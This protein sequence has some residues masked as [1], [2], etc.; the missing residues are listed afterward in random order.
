MDIHYNAFISYRHHP[1]DIKVA[2]QI[3]RGLEHYRI[4]KPLNQKIHTKLRLFRDKEELP[5]T[6]NLTDTITQALNNSEYLIVICSPHTR[7]SIWVQREIETFLQTHDRTRILTVIAE[8][9]PYNVIPEILCAEEQ[10]DP[11]TGQTVSVPVEPLSCDWRA[12]KRKAYREELPRLA[13]ALLEC[14][15]DELRQRERQYQ[16]RRMAAIFSAALAAALTLSAYVIHNSIKIQQANNQLT[17]ANISILNNLQQAQ[18]NQSQFLASA[19]LQQAD[20]GDRMQAMALALEALPHEDNPRPYVVR[21]EKALADA[22]GAYLSQE[23]VAAVGVITCDAYVDLF[24][25]TDQRDWLFV[26]DQRELL[27][28]WELETFQQVAATPLESNAIELLVTP[29]DTAIVHT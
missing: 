8:G 25:A 19:A 9:E 13:A 10:L 1:S 29:D 20:A 7:E 15:Y 3:H 28:V 21:A 12:S 16:T 27:S 6:S 18:I 2:E 11:I 22:V 5:I 14:G 24:S 26:T 23:E 17:D 4:P